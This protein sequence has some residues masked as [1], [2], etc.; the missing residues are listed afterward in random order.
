MKTIQRNC[1]RL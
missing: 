1:G